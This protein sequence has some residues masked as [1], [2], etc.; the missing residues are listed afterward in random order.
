MFHVKVKFSPNVKF[1][2]QFTHSAKHSFK[3]IIHY[4]NKCIGVQSLR[5]GTHFLVLL[6]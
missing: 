3:L 2:R 5:I 6:F 4:L 1:Y